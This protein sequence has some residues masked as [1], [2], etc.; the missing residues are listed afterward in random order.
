MPWPSQGPNPDPNYINGQR[1]FIVL[2][3]LFFM[4]AYALDWL[5]NLFSPLTTRLKITGGILLGALCAGALLWNINIY[6]FS[7]QDFKTYGDTYWAPLG[8]N[9]I[10][11]AE[12]LE[13]NYPRCHIL[14]DPEY[15]SSTV[16]LLTRDQ[17]KYLAVNPLILPLDYKVDKNVIMVFR[18]GDFDE[19]RIRQTYP[20]A[21]WGE[22]KDSGNGILVKT[23][24]VSKTD[25]DAL[26]N[27]KQPTMSLP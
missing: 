13:A 26:Q 21:V 24:E 20:N 11:V 22:V 12:Y 18:P 10:R 6:Y 16:Q 15:N 4:V 1:Y 14:L 5:L 2:P 9:H 19:N 23:V 25:I 17:V 27:G 8:F 7:F 3:F